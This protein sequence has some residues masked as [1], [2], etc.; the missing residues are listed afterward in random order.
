MR[1]VTG[2]LI[3]EVGTVLGDVICGFGVRQALGTGSRTEV[4]EEKA[5]PEYE[6]K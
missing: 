4:L 2:R 6:A 3:T 5:A 1:T